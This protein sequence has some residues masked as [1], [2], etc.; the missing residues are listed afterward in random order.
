VANRLRL[1]KILKLDFEENAREDATPLKL[2]PLPKL[3]NR[4]V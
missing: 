2:K 1:L 4:M 3:I